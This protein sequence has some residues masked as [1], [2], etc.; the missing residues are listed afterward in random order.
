[1]DYYTANTLMADDRRKRLMREASTAR[2][3]GAMQ[4]YRSSI[5]ARMLARMAQWMITEGT[6]L[7]TRYETQN[8]HSSRFSVAS[9]IETLIAAD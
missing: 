2:L 9:P 3:A 1:M 6:R 5:G 7:K 8:V 4:V